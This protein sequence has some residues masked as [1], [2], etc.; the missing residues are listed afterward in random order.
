V[1]R[2]DMELYETPKANIDFARDFGTPYPEKGNL[3]VRAM[4]TGVIQE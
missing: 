4:I 1:R 2:F 3:S